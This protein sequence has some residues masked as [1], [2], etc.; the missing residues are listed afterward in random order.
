MFLLYLDPRMCFFT[1]KKEKIS[2]YFEFANAA[3][4][5]APR[6]HNAGFVVCG[7]ESRIHF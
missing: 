7:P 3:V 6:L 2:A 5:F 4:L 1:K